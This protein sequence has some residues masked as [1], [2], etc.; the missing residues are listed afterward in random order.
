MDTSKLNYSF[1]D[2][3]APTLGSYSPMVA[4]VLGVCHVMPGSGAVYG[5]ALT[6]PLLP[7]NWEKPL[8]ELEQRHFLF[9]QS[10]RAQQG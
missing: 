1:H 10:L 7:T 9:V 8:T 5:D 6:A 4:D 3:P 2:F